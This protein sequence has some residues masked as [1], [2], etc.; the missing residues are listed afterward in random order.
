MAVLFLGG[1]IS[2][3][4]IQLQRIIMFLI[5]SI[6][7]PKGGIRIFKALGRLANNSTF[8]LAKLEKNLPKSCLC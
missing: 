3:A 5:T 2:M 7:K 1:G 6:I 8:L 4:N